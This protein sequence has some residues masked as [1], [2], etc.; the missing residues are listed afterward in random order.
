M[1]APGMSAEAL[2]ELT[3]T[4]GK[5]IVCKAA[6]S[7]KCKEPLQV[8][9]V[10]VGAPKAGEVRIMIVANALCHTDVYT[11]DGHDPEGKFPFI[12]GHEAAAIVESV[13]EGVTSV[14]PG[15]VVI[16]CYTPECKRKDC[17]FCMSVETNLCPRI[18]ATQGAGV[19]PDG[20]SRFSTMDGQMINHFMGCS[21]FAEYSVIAEISAAK[22]DS[23]ADLSQM[24][25]IG[26]GVST[27]WGAVFNTMKV[28]YGAQSLAVF[29]LGALG[30]SVIQAAKLLRVRKIVGVD[31]NEGKFDVAKKMGATHCINSLKAPDK[32]VKKALL[33]LEPWGFQY[34]FDCT[35]NVG[36]M[37]D[38]LECCHRGF[39][40]S[41]VIGVAAAG[42]EISTRPFQLVTGRRWA[43]T[44][45]GGWKSRTEVPGLVQSVLR[46]DMELKTYIT[47]TFDGLEHV[48]EALKELH[49]GGCL[50]AVVNICKNPIPKDNRNIIKK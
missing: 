25:L 42:K 16:S 41:C 17:I 46:Q 6:V 1:C 31:I 50:R 2:A 7:F 11:I 40:Q 37:R 38:A 49:G 24:C 4:A 32:D 14:K 43:G 35:G 19:M 22:V 30:L 21:T 5:E 8:V 9:D 48:N 45:F 3:S 10:K 34:T 20:T 13:G 33:E 15:D 27:G 23:G 44:A 12:P 28:P 39:G 36:V 29:G 26:C 18:R 47:H